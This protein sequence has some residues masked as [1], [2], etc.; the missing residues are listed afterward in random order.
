MQIDMEKKM[1]KTN[2]QPY[3]NYGMYLTGTRINCTNIENN[4]F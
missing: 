4:K 3:L 2:S 1:I